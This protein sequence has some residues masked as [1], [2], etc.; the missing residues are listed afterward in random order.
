MYFIMPRVVTE[1]YIFAFYVLHMINIHHA[2]A[3]MAEST[4]F[5]ACFCFEVW[6]LV[7]AMSRFVL[8]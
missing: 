7:M 6:F 1:L 3:L 5:Q 2:R 4:G 8:K